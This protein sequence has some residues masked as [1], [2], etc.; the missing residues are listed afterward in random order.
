MSVGDAQPGLRQNLD[1][2]GMVEVA[3]DGGRLDEVKMSSAVGRH[4]DQTECL[5][6]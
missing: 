5:R 1:E 2:D 4:S 3:A 6:K